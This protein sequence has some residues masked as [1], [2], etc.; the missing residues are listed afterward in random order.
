MKLGNKHIFKLVRII[1]KAGVR[2]L[3]VKLL[4]RQEKK[5]AESIGIDMFDIIMEMFD[6]EEIE[7]LIYE[8]LSDVSGKTVD[9]LSNMDI[10]ETKNLIQSIAAEN[11]LRNFFSSVSVILR[12]I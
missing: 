4:K 11:N 3:V 12:K 9:D 7:Y 2:D 8:L 5:D 1:K 6:S 10:E